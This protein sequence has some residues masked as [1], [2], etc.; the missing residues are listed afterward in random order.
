MVLPPTF[1]PKSIA[2]ACAMV[3]FIAAVA[4]CAGTTKSHDWRDQPLG[5]WRTPTVFV[6]IFG[7][8]KLPPLNAATNV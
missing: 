6:R 5:T 3:C 7:W 1:P 8:G 4:G 2:W